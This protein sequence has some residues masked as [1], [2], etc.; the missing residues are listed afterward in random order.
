VTTIKTT[1]AELAILGGPPAFAERLHVGRPN[2]GD[3]ARL[4]ERFN[5]ILDSRWLTN[6]GP[7]VREFEQRVEQFVRE[8]EQR[9]VFQ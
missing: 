5:R 2:I 3:R 9:V 8:F 6:D 1:A 7:F 4:I